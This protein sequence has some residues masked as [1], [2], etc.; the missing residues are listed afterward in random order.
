MA[1]DQIQFDSHKVPEEDFP[2]RPA[3]PEH[4]V[5]EGGSWADAV[6]LVNNIPRACPSLCVW[7]LLRVVAPVKKLETRQPCVCHLEEEHSGNEAGLK[8]TGTVITANPSFLLRR[9]VNL[10]SE[11]SVH[12]GT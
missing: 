8:E 10:H 6:A 2:L 11:C 5:Q 7:W 12:W 9:R 1:F 3:R 4:G